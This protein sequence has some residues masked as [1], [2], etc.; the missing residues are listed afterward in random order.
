MMGWCMI[1]GISTSSAG[2]G[3]NPLALGM[4]CI[5]CYLHTSGGWEKDSVCTNTIMNRRAYVNHLKFH[6]SLPHGR[7]SPLHTTD[8]AKLG[9]VKTC[10]V[11]ECQF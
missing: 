2:V 3:E 10:D 6:Y 4:P 11:N 7:I 8:S 1:S 5:R 9:P